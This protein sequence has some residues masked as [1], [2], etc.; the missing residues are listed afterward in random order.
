MRTILIIFVYAFLFH[1]GT[2]ILYANKSADNEIIIKFKDG[3]LTENY[4]N[5]NGE[6]LKTKNALI[7]TKISQKSRV[8]FQ[9]HI[10]DSTGDKTEIR[11]VA[12]KFFPKDSISISRDGKRVN[13]SDILNISVID[14]KDTTRNIKDI[15]DSLRNLDFI[16]Y[17]EP[18]YLMQVN[19]NP[20]NDPRYYLQRG[21]EQLN[22]IDIDA[23]RAWDFTTGN[24]GIKV[25]VIDDGI[26]YD[27]EDLGDGVFGVSGA[28]VRGGWDYINNNS[29]P[30]FKGEYGCPSHGTEVAGIIGANRN[31][32]LGISGLAG[33]NGISN[34]GCQLFSLKVGRNNDCKYPTSLI[35]EAILDGSNS[36]P[37]YGCHILNISLG[38]YNY[39]ES[40]R[41]AIRV[42][43]QNNVVVVASKGNEY[44]TSFHYPS[45]YDASWIVSVGAT[46]SAD[47]KASFSNMGNGIDVAAPGTTYL[48]NTTTPVENGS[49]TSFSGTSA[50]APIVSGQAALILAE[51]LEQGISLHHNDVEWLI[52]VSAEDVNS[53]TLP[54]YDDDLG[55]GR[56]NVGK[57]LEMMNK[58]WVINHHSATGGTVVNATDWFNM[59]LYNPGG[60]LST[61]FYS[62]KR[63]EVQKTV[64]MPD[65]LNDGYVWCR[66]SNET[67]GWSDEIPNH[68]MGFSDVV[69]R[70]GNSVTLRTYIYDIYTLGGGHV[71]M[72]P[73]TSNNVVFAYT[74]LGIPCYQNLHVWEHLKPGTENQSVVYSVSNDLTSSSEI[75]SG[76]D[77]VFKAG[78]Q[79]K[80]WGGF[81][82][83]SGSNFHA[84]IESCSQTMYKASIII[85]EDPYNIRQNIN[86]SIVPNPTGEITTINLSLT[87]SSNVSLF[88][89]DLQ[90][91]KIHEFISNAPLQAGRHSFTLNAANIQSGMYYVHLTS[92]DGVLTEPLI[93]AK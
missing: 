31:N 56:V 28:K 79:I 47:Y 4:L 38:G 73:A 30:D 58:P 33:G 29:D 19:G 18:N 27:N 17:A 65:Y 46:N 51:A 61:G 36:S 10:N 45:D 76:A 89:F 84:K 92:P 74:T 53:S 16:V 7:L 68:Q 13:I 55:H 93:I 67:I 63:F 21:L 52:K 69:L 15:C 86:L 12:R 14:I 41:G 78:N 26:D 24:S 9:N 70:D 2:N 34:T 87:N 39:S 32:N 57:S 42:A 62:V 88:V 5:S 40:Y 90:G 22:D 54:G 44:S 81:Q 49:Y 91:N 72:R 83:K 77:I 82:A 85:D 1:L 75:D 8:R 43:A 3:F 59:I 35:I 60:G 20:P 48:I 37:G 71:G 66:S 50:S 23:N 64:T 11:K 25:G 80:L 6:F